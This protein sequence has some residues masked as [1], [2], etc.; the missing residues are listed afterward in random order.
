MLIGRPG[1]HRVQEVREPALVLGAELPRPVDAA[2]AQHAGGH[3]EAA[4]VVQHVLV[5]RALGAAIGR[6]EARAAGPRRCRARAGR[7]RSAGRRRRPGP[8]G[9]RPG[10]RRPCWC[11]RTPAAA[12]RAW[13]RSASSTLQRAAQ[14]DVEIALRVG[15]AGGD[16]DLGGHVEHRRHARSTARS[17]CVAV[18]HVGDRPARCGRRGGAAASRGSPPRPAGP[19]RRTPITGARARPAGP[20]GCCR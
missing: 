19:A 2:H 13:R 8:A 5:G 11:W 4:R 1:Q 14:V 9:C 16:R 6:V 10:R 12:G 7:R 18:A 3:A 17:S 20:P 15:Q